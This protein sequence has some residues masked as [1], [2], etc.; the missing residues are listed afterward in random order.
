MHVEYEEV[1]EFDGGLFGF[2]EEEEVGDEDLEVED[3]AFE[4][5][6]VEDE[7]GLNGFGGGFLVFGVVEAFGDLYF[8]ELFV[9]VLVV[10]EEGFVGFAESLCHF[11]EPQALFLFHVY[12]EIRYVY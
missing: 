1:V 6:Y 9:E 12:F 4:V 3:T 8:F 11:D 2:G 10:G 7:V 5:F